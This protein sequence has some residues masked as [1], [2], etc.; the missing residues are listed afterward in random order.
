MAKKVIKIDKDIVIDYD[1][2][3]VK[4]ESDTVIVSVEESMKLQ[5]EGYNVINIYREN[6]IKLHVLV[7]Q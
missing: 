4:K 1:P 5:K 3:E 6:G 7:K 2:I